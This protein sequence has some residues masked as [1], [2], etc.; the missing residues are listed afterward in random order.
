MM[1]NSYDCCSRGSVGLNLVA[2]HCTAFGDSQMLHLCNLLGRLVI[3]EHSA[4]DHLHNRNM[5]DFVLY[6]SRGHS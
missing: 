5:D 6:W 2:F 1:K 4:L 3:I